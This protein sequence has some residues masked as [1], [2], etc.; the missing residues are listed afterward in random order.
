[1][2]SGDTP[3]RSKKLFTVRVDGVTTDGQRASND[4]NTS[5]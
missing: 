2:K 3:C 1:M 4:H 5:H